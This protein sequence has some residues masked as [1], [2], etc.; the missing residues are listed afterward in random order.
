MKKIILTGSS[1]GF[2]LLAAR[3]LAAKGH[4]VYATMRNTKG[5]NAGVAAALKEWAKQQKAAIEV[6]ELDVANGNS[7]AEAVKTMAGLSGGRVDVLFNNAG[8]SFTG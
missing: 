3:T 7:V 8:I 5:S 2:G 1:S 6:V 4:T